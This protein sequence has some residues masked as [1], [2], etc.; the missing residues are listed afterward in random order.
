MNQDLQETRKYIG[1]YSYIPKFITGEG[2][3][4][5]VYQ[6]I[7]DRTKEIVAIKQ[8]DLKIFTRDEYLK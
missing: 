2:A 4:S 7:D 3:F 1:G 5:K 6:G 8:L